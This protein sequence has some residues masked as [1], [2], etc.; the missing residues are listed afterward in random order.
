MNNDATR[1]PPLHRLEAH[2]TEVRGRRILRTSPVKL[3]EKSGWALNRWP[4]RRRKRFE[5]ALSLGVSHHRRPTT[6][7]PPTTFQT[8]S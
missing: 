3:S 2:I 4:D 5:G 8:V 6:K 1:R 7:G